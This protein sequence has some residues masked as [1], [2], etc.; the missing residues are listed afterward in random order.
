MG[1]TFG[2][3][4]VF[5]ALHKQTAWGKPKEPVDGESK[6]FLLE[7]SGKNGE[8][9]SKPLDEEEINGSK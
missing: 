4:L 2:V 5:L 7:V 6:T 9:K 3:L 8:I 1:V